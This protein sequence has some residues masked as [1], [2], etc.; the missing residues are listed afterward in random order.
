M[1]Q[2]LV[3]VES[4]V[5]TDFHFIRNCFLDTL[6]LARYI[7]IVEVDVCDEMQTR[8]HVSEIHFIC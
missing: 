4:Y 5:W 6:F 8:L 1:Y 7:L 2:T 3:L